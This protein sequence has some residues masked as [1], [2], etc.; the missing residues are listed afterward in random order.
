MW[1]AW[2][3][4]QRRV[5]RKGESTFWF[6]GWVKFA[7]IST[8]RLTVDRQKV[9][10]LNIKHFSSSFFLNETFIAFLTSKHQGS[11]P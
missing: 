5:D 10:Q 2:I 1:L 11:L 4:G 6:F 3:L 7:C 9:L 8:S